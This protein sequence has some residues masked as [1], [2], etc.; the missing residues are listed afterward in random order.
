M[1]PMTDA[2]RS[3]TIV[4]RIIKTQTSAMVGF[5]LLYVPLYVFLPN[6][7]AAAFLWA[8]GSLPALVGLPYGFLQTWNRLRTSIH[9]DVGAAERTMSRARN[10]CIAVG[11]LSLAALVFV[12]PMSWTLAAAV[13]VLGLGNAIALGI[14]FDLIRRDLRSR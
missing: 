13:G 14:T 12:R 5:S 4:R 8:G 11:G 10:G 7:D 3:I 1:S 9:D 6:A 2:V